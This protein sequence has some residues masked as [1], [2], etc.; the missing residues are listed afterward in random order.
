MGW[1]LTL[2]IGALT[3]RERLDDREEAHE[4]KGPMLMEAEVE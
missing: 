3:W 4:E 2:M 1:V